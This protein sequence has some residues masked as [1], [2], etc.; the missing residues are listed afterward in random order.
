M[1]RRMKVFAAIVLT[2][3]VFPAYLAAS[4]LSE[5]EFSTWFNDIGNRFAVDDVENTGL[6]V[7]PTLNIPMG[8]EYEAMGTAYTAVSRE[9]SFF[10]A[11]PA[12]S[13]DLRYTELALYHNNLIADTNMESIV[14]TT[15]RDDFGVGVGG[16]FLYVPFTEYDDFGVQQ[17]TARYTE[18]IVGVNASYNFLNSFYFN[19][20]SVGANAKVAYRH[21]SEVIASDLS[22]PGIMFDVGLL[23]R[24]NVLKFFSARERNAAAGLTV[25][26]LG[27]NVLGEP[28]PSEIAVGVAYKPLR[29]W[30]ISADTT[31]PVTPF[32]S[33]PAAPLGYAM[34]S[35]VSVT[36]FFTARGGFGID[37][38][39]P[40]VSMG[41]AVT[42]EQLIV[43]L[44]YT[45]DMTTQLSSFDRISLNVRFNFGDQGRAA[46]EA[47]V[48]E[49]Y[50]DALVAFAA[51]DL[52]RTIALC[53]EAL[54][55]DPTFQPARETLTT[56]AL[57]LDLQN[58]MESIRSGEQADA[59]A[60]GAPEATE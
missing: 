20:V 35:A 49:L 50:L 13:S 36:D 32:S 51:G 37:G 40:R 27:P 44:N 54:E 22:A 8:G 18:T 30:L 21:I 28:L 6:T 57:S 45:L 14:Y 25:R 10:E 24:F 59:S 23:S 2:L 34:G 53:E 41:G 7:F 56:A 11:N 55:L 19:G 60:I 16:K 47:R 26:N 3:A 42:V 39:N 17:G 33:Q 58:E 29:P 15:R 4:G 12:G 46:R 52:E 1:Y 38:G 43:S 31:I 5:D 9:S 48:R